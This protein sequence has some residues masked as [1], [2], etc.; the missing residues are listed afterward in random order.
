MALAQKGEVKMK[1]TNPQAN[2]LFAV[3]RELTAHSLKYSNLEQLEESLKNEYSGPE[4]DLVRFATN[5]LHLGTKKE[6]DHMDLD[7]IAERWGAKDGHF[8]TQLWL[9]KLVAQ[10]AKECK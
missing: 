2:V 8:G 6:L 7:F 9:D 4:E 10:S 1:L 5:M 3:L